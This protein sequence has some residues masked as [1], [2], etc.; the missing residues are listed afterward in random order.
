MCVHSRLFANAPVVA[1]WAWAAGSWVSRSPESCV[2]VWV[3]PASPCSHAACLQEE[4]AVRRS[5][6]PWNHHRA[7]GHG[8]WD[9]DKLEKQSSRKTEWWL[10]YCDFTFYI[11]TS[12]F[13]SF[14]PAQ[15]AVIVEVIWS[16]P[17]V[18]F[19]PLPLPTGPVQAFNVGHPVSVYKGRIES[20]VSRS[21]CMSEKERMQVKDERA[22]TQYSLTW[23]L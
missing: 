19:T 14:K 7:G 12:D 15:P 21:M 4:R 13:Q 10:H 2:R 22:Y 20:T 16:T 23:N 11:C 5:L 6:K 18:V 3:H 17:A 8:P 1:F 9:R